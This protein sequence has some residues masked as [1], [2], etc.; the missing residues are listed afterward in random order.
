MG[1]RSKTTKERNR[2]TETRGRAATCP[3]YGDLGAVRSDGAVW[4]AGH[5][6]ALTVGDE[7]D[8]ACHWGCGVAIG[9][10]G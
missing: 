7:D 5:G 1:R 9:L 10:N 6:K 3:T 2:A 4:Q 8:G